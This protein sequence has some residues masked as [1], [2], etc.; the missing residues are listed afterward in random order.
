MLPLLFKYK[1]NSGREHVL[2]PVQNLADRG[3]PYFNC[4]M[5][6]MFLMTE[7]EYVLSCISVANGFNK[8]Q[9]SPVVS[10]RHSGHQ[11]WSGHRRQHPHD[12]RVFHSLFL[13]YS[14][15]P[16]QPV[17]AAAFGFLEVSGSRRGFLVA[18]PSLHTC[19]LQLGSSKGKGQTSCLLSFCQPLP[20]CRV[21]LLCRASASD[22]LC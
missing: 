20:I 21:E 14:P 7:L 18:Q 16:S 2:C 17:P 3:Y 8:Y 5:T 1:L 6:H 19:T 10:V 13:P 4:W 22:S 9:S 12:P 11:L 15:A